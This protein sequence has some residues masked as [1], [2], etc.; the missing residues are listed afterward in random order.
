MKYNV[1]RTLAARYHIRL[2]YLFGSQTERGRRYLEGKDAEPELLSDLDVAI[3]FENPPTEAMKTY[4]VLFRE[5]SEI[6]APFS[7][8]L[9][10]MH[11]V[12]S[13]FQYQIIKG[14]RIYEEA[15]SVADDFEE[16]VMKMAEDLSFK[17]RVFDDDVMD[18]I[19]NGYFE[20]EYSPHS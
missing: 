5:I 7:I 10:F 15:E 11:E 20:F 12:G 18:A 1:I 16:R 4:G 19:E 2:M 6:F 8:D 17:K 14:F 9:V 13:L 3:V